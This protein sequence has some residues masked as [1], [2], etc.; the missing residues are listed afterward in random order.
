MIQNI[1]VSNIATISHLQRLRANEKVSIKGPK[2]TQRTNWAKRHV[3]SK[4]VVS[5]IELSL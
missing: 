1:K 2:I 5:V 4:D 3:Y